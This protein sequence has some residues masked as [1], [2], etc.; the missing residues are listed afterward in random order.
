MEYIHCSTFTSKHAHAVQSGECVLVIADK[1]A[2][3][4]MKNME[5]ISV[6][7]VTAIGA[8]SPLTE[9]GKIL[10]ND[11]HASC[12]SII[13][14]HEFVHNFILF[15]YRLIPNFV[16]N[17]DFSQLPYFVRFPLTFIEHILPY[18]SFSLF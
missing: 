7:N 5:I 8:Y 1:S 13:T 12:Y 3:E 15:F 4:L 9:N 14:Q 11:I 2:D 16:K 6:D 17:S 18:E 10:V